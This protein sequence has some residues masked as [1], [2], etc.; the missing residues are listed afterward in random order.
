MMEAGTSGKTWVVAYTVLQLLKALEG[1]LISTHLFAARTEL[2][3]GRATRVTGK[4]G[5]NSMVKL[6]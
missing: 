3:T 4:S 6:V 5:A 2:L 1:N